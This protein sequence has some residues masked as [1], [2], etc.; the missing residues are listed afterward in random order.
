MIIYFLIA[1]F[2]TTIGAIAGLG[3]GV[4]IK[5]MLQIGSDFSIININILS[6]I[7]VFSMAITSLIKRKRANTFYKVEN[8]YYIII[9][10]LLGGFLGNKIFAVFI[11]FFES[12]KK[13]ES[14][15]IVLLILFLL[16][17]LIKDI[18]KDLPKIKGS[19]IN[20]LI[21]GIFLSIL[22]TF[23]G[24]GGGPINV[25]F[26]IIL[27]KMDIKTSAFLSIIIIFFSQLVNIISYGFSGL[28]FSN[29]LSPLLLMVPGAIL[30]G[31]IGSYLATKLSSRQISYIFNVVII[32]VIVLNVYSFLTL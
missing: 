25:S 24:I 10:S 9:G 12:E 6:S 28:Y 18:F 17:I 29:D 16:L 23:L 31:I 32:S 19:K 7:T 27:F 2:A 1:I 5:P 26:F 8:M 4:I 21:V 20:Y 22:C 13:V 14:F 30:G 11:S 3:G 15:Q